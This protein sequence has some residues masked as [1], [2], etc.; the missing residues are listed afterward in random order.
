MHAATHPLIHFA[1]LALLACN[2]GAPED[3]RLNLL[4]ITVDT[5]RADHLGSYGYER[6]TSPA[7]DQLAQAGVVF[8]QAHATSSWTLPSLASLIGSA[9]PL[10]HRCLGDNRPLPARIETLAE[11]LSQ[12]GYR[13]GAIANHIFLGRR[14]QMDQGY[15]HY[16]DELALQYSQ[17]IASQKAITSGAVT[18][19]ALS[20]LDG[21]ASLPGPWHLWLHYFDPHSSYQPHPEHPTSFDLD[22]PEDLYDGEIAFTDHHLGRLF[23]YLEQ[24]GL[25]ENTAI[26]LVADHGEEFQEHGGSM[27]RRTLFEEV[28]RVPLIIKVPGLPSGRV[29]TSVSIVDVAPTL[30]ELAGIAPS[31]AYVGTSLVPALRG[32]RMAPRPHT[33]LLSEPKIKLEVL[34]QG[35]WKLIHDHKQGRTQLFN[36]VNDP[37]EQDDLASSQRQLCKS[38]RHKMAELRRAASEQSGPEQRAAPIQLNQADL[39]TLK[40][41]GYGGDENTEGK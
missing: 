31:P 15:A 3:G 7:M 27:H 4:L 18:D 34:I 13:T 19:K 38:M 12:A 8:E 6:A 41:L 1:S 39:S 22:T 26:V 17:R 29:S 14:Y 2:P 20:W 11:H 25:A 32:E 37:L 10:D 40:G 5:L 28:L 16:D 30:L 9:W 35:N 33:A 23:D 21:Q 24:S 36:L